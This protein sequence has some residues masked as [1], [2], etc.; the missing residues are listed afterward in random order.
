[1]GVDGLYSPGSKGTTLDYLTPLL[2]HTQLALLSSDTDDRTTLYCNQATNGMKSSPKGSTHSQLDSYSVSI[3]DHQS[4]GGEKGGG[5]VGAGVGE[6][7][8]EDSW[9][10]ESYMTWTDTA[11]HL[12]QSGDYFLYAPIYPMYFFIHNHLSCL[13]PSFFS[14]FFFFLSSVYP[15]ILLSSPPRFHPFTALCLLASSKHNP[16]LVPGSISLYNILTHFSTSTSTSTLTSTS[17]SYSYSN[18]YTGAQWD[19]EWRHKGQTQLHL[20]ISSFSPSPIQKYMDAF[21]FTLSSAL[22]AGHNQALQDRKGRNALFIMCERL[23][24]FSAGERTAEQ[25]PTTF[26][27]IEF[28]IDFFYHMKGEY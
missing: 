17:Y 5:R 13:A 28:S 6:G 1:M 24:L 27:S 10:D 4:K 25:P 3:D 7:V 19:V 12:I 18:S 2:D 8:G 9:V 21:C 26:S 22:S 11:M 20:L 16:N 15:S 14:S 23:S